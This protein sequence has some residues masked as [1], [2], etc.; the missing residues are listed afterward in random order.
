MPASD[1]PTSSR[2][3]VWL[4]ALLGLV[5]YALRTNIAIAQEYMAPELG[6]S[7]VQMGVISAWGFQLAY[8][9]GQVPGGAMGDR[10]GARLVLAVASMGWA[11]AS[12]ASG[13]VMGYMRDGAHDRR[14]LQP[15][16]ATRRPPTVATRSRTALA[17]RLRCG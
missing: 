6:L 1:S 8:T 2:R 9:I 14:R 3:V 17:T 7:M 12:L 15:T 10:Y 11:V 16:R 5:A 13:A 4:L